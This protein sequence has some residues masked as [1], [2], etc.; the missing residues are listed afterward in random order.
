M[1]EW[2]A[3]LDL[4]D[5]VCSFCQ[6]K[7]SEDALVICINCSTP[8]HDSC[9]E[10][11]GECAAFGCGGI[12]FRNM[13][14]I[15]GRVSMPE[16]DCHWVSREPVRRRRPGPIRPR[17]RAPS[18]IGT[19]ALGAVVSIT[20]MLNI[21]GLSL[22]AGDFITRFEHSCSVLNPSHTAVNVSQ[23]TEETERTREG[24]SGPCPICHG[25]G[26]A[27][28][29]SWDKRICATCSGTGRIR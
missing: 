21:L 12:A 5:G 29:E 24:L 27:G 7:L 1:G 22:S 23:V 18:I 6:G 13:E 3:S 4:S 8:Y 20:I 14:E 25:K 28:T 2:G 19:V 11:L 15:E 17:N 10:H 26:L 16:A 9:F